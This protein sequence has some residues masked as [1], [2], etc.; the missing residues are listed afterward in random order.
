MED[1]SVA[2][3]ESIAESERHLQVDRTQHQDKELLAHFVEKQQDA[4]SMSVSMC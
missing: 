1:D 2:L 4:V 3:G